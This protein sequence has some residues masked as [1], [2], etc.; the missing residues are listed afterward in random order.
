[1][2]VEVYPN[3]KLPPPPDSSPPLKKKR[4][5]RKPKDKI[6]CE[7]E[8]TCTIQSLPNPVLFWWD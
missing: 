2:E 4:K 8:I 7:G 6:G 5:P 3:Q 1:V